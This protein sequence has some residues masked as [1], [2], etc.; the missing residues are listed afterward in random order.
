MGHDDHISKHKRSQ[1]KG[2]REHRKK[3]HKSD[4]DG[5]NSKR[6]KDDVN[7]AHIVDEDVSGDDMWIEKNIDMDGERVSSC[8]D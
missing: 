4:K 3:R 1:D 2:D 8:Y 5:H 7:R 6:K